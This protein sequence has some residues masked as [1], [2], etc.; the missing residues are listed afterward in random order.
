MPELKVVVNDPEAGEPRPVWVRVVGVESVG[1]VQLEFTVDHKEK[2]KIPVAYANPK[3][4]KKLNT[5]Y[6]YVTL[7]IWKNRAAGEKLNITL[8]VMPSEEV[9]PEELHVSKA[10][11]EELLGV[12]RT[13][14]EVFRS[15]SF[16]I[17]VS[18]RNAEV[19]LGRKIGDKVPADVVGIQG[20]ELLITGGSDLT[21]APMLPSVHGPVKKYVL[22]SG[23]PGFHPRKKGERRRKLVRGNT[24]TED[25]VQIN[26]KLV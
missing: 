14:G 9:P 5:P 1:D 24:I 7:R 11:L 17:L 21:G 10:M 25:I 13:V 4:V 26:T 22:L 15:K 12:E 23:P 3:L 18:G 6:G 20:K 16:Q 19:F 8:K 2:K